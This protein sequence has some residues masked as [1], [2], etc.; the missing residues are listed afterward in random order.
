MASTRE[1][2]IQI[3]GSE[4]VLDSPMLLKSFA[5]DRS[6]VKPIT[7][8][9]VLKVKN[10]EE[11]KALVKLANQTGTPLVP[12]SSGEPHFRGDTVPSVP[13]AV[14]VDLSGMKR[15]IHVDPRNRMALVEPGITYA[16]LQPELVKKGLRLSSPM[17]P[18]ANKS[19]IASL[20]EREP[21]L[22]P[23]TMRES[24]VAS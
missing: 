10:L 23:R 11:V 18:R 24:K 5:S 9:F 1:A 22:V 20:L 6:F 14:M 4:N 2:L 19:V 16:E 7:P 8:S 3:V 21:G 13:G 15:I 17:A 12:V